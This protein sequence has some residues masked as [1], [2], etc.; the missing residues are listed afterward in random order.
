MKTEIYAGRF[1]ALGHINRLEIFQAL[2]KAG[3]EGLAIGQIA[4][5][6]DIPASTL[7]FHLRELVRSKLVS[8]RKEGRTI[9]CAANFD[10][11]NELL[12]FVKK[13]C[14]KGVALPVFSS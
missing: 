2:V 9:T 12:I 1:A 14:C 10:A 13:D 8:Q 5:M 11:L 6:L 4:S 7:S 3:S